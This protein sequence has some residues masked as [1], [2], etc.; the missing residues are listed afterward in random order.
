MKVMK[1]G[2]YGNG[3]F[4]KCLKQLFKD[5]NL[6]IY[7]K[8]INK[9]LDSKESVL[10]CDIIFLSIPINQIENVVKKEKFNKN[11]LI[12]DVCSVKNK[13]I[14]VITSNINNDY[15]AT[16]PLFGLDSLEY[17]KLWIYDDSYCSKENSDNFIKLIK[18]IGCKTIKVEKDYHDK[19]INKKQFLAHLISRVVDKVDDDNVLYTTNSYQKIKSVSKDLI[20][21]DDVLF[22]DMYKYNQYNQDLIDSIIKVL[23]NIK[24]KL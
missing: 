9:R 11:S 1:I 5:Y 4:T 21:D 10:N 3:R 18:S 16:H 15:I 12:I 7:D 2:I 6:F 23:E 19:V 8:D 20:K 24:E 17:D 14:D 13:V 22:F